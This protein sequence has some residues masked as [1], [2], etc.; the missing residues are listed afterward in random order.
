MTAQEYIWQC[1]QKKENTFFSQEEKEVIQFF[2]EKYPY[3][4]ALQMLNYISNNSNTSLYNLSLYK[5]DPFLFY[6]KV[7]PYLDRNNQ[8]IKAEVLD[9]K[10]PL[11]DVLTLINELPNEPLPIKPKAMIKEQLKAKTNSEEEK[12]T[13]MVMMS[14]TDWLNHFKYKK[15][16]EEAEAQEKKALK[17]AWKLE[18]L[19]AIIEEEPNDDI[20]EPIF[21]Q[22][23]DSIAE[24]DIISETMAKLYT[25]QG[26]KDKAIYIYQKLS[27]LNPEKSNYFALQIEKLKRD[28][29]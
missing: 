20:P 14:F 24:Q 25:Q 4:P 12:N 16:E 11:P 1:L 7:K 17:T 8:E 5:S 21:R 28:D 19:S 27:L 29:I 10:K 9:E 2:T 22:A 13:L 18:K 3:M 26:K 23:L 6:K 15:Q